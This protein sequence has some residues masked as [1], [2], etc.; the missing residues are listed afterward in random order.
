MAYYSGW[1]NAVPKANHAR[2]RT[3]ATR[4]WPHFERLGALRMVETWGVDIKPGKVTDFLRATKATPDETVA[5]GWVEWPDRAT[6]DAA[7]QAMMTDDSVAADIG[8]MPFDGS[9]MFWGGFAPII[10]EGT[11]LNATYF[12]GYLVA[13]PTANKAAYTKVAMEAWEQMFR[14]NGCLGSFE[15]WGE[16]VPH[17][18]ITDMYQ[19]VNATEGETIVFSWTAWPDRATC[20]AAGEKMEAE[21][22]GQPMPEMPFDMTRMVWAGFDLLFDSDQV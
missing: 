5:L 16:D 9:R 2:Y 18:K 3:H 20:D 7:W 15:C 14:P 22:A 21:M 11:D 12:Q 17:G 1:V 10:A 4:A 13:V 6:A 8:D 19:A